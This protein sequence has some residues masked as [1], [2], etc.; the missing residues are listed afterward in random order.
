[1]DLFIKVEAKV[2]S[3]NNIEVYIPETKL[4]WKAPEYIRS[5]PQIVA[6]DLSKQMAAEFIKAM[7]PAI[8]K[9]ANEAAKGPSIIVP[10]DIGKK[11]N[12]R[13]G[14]GS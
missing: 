11:R 6:S 3:K 5:H 14:N 1:M 9:A 12:G 10:I 4:E 8:I 7:V 13:S 2:N